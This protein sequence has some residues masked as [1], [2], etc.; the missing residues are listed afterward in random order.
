MTEPPY[1]HR[2]NRTISLWEGAVT[3]TFVVSDPRFHLAAYWID[4]EDWEGLRFLLEYGHRI[5]I[6]HFVVESTENPATY[7]I[8]PDGQDMVNSLES[9]CARI[10]KFLLDALKGQD[11]E[12]MLLAWL[13]R[14]A[15]IM[16]RQSVLPHFAGVEYDLDRQ[17]ARVQGELATYQVNLETTT[18]SVLWPDGHTR[19][20]CLHP[21]TR[22]LKVPNMTEKELALACKI[23]WL[24]NDRLLYK[25][26][27]G[28]RSAV[29]EFRSAVKEGLVPEVPT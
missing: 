23:I 8:Y 12:L 10:A 18:A 3:R 27:G 7:N 11:V 14:Y 1:F 2:T 21:S 20:M 4:Y 28:F 17:V 26:V 13:E 25:S 19:S 22:Q 15:Q 5:P 24:H 6:G 16:A 9:H 29:N